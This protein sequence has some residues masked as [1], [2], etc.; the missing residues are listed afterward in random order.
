MV[1]VGIFFAI[2]IHDGILRDLAAKLGAEWE[3]FAT[4]LGFKSAEIQRFSL[5]GKNGPIVNVIFAMLSVWQKRQPQKVDVRKTLI[6]A[7][8][9]S[10]RL[11]LA[12]DL[13]TRF[14]QLKNTTGMF[15]Q[16]YTLK[17]AVFLTGNRKIYYTY[18]NVIFTI[19]RIFTSKYRK[20]H[21]NKPFTVK[22]P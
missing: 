7:L 8:E 20:N 3:L 2:D 10:E 5:D 12:R 19:Y 9:K 18:F 1:S 14:Y 22:L 17:N 15:M 13:S 6:D 21:E 16:A 11:D 4:N